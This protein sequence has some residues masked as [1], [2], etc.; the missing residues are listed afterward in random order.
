MSTL[1]QIN[2]KATT[3]HTKRETGNDDEKE[4]NAQ[5]MQL[6]TLLNA[7]FEEILTRLGVTEKFKETLKTI[8]NK[9]SF[10]DK[11]KLF[12]ELG[13]KRDE[14][15]ELKTK[16]DKLLEVDKELKKIGEKNINGKKLNTNFKEQWEKLL[17]S[18]GD[19]QG[20]ILIKKAN[21]GCDDL[22]KELLIAIDN[23]IVAVNE[24]IQTELDQNT[25]PV[26]DIGIV[27]NTEIKPDA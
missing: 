7:R 12:E 6:K 5:D 25:H 15:S 11:Y 19:L 23:K 14:K 3:E 9:Y 16:F 1:D 8:A 13:L 20:L 18:L 24:F 2:I 4:Q 22:I 10:E 17:G 21:K 27:N 26:S